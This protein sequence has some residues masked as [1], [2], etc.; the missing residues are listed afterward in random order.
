MN[1]NIINFGSEKTV[2]IHPEQLPARFLKKI[3]QHTG[4]HDLIYHQLEIW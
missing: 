2:K 1:T 3:Y 4:T